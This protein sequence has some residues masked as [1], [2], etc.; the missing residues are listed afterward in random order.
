MRI[1]ELIAKLSEM[2][3]EHGDVVVQSVD[4]YSD[5][6]DYEIQTVTFDGERVNL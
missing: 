1:K 3:E 4:M 2:L 6:S 5:D